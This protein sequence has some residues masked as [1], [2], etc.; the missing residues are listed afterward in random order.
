MPL[1]ILH[2]AVSAACSACMV[3]RWLRLSADD[4]RFAQFL[5]WLLAGL[6]VMVALIASGAVLGPAG[7]GAAAGRLGWGDPLWRL[8]VESSGLVLGVT[9]LYFVQRYNLL[10]LSLSYRSLR[11][12]A[13]LLA[14]VGLVLLVGSALGAGGTDELRRAVAWGLLVALLATAIYTPL[15]QAALRR[16]V[17]LRRLLG[18][19]ITAEELE[20]FT[21]TLQSFDLGEEGMRRLTAREIGQWL[22]TRARFLPEL[23][24]PP[25]LGALRRPTSPVPSTASTPRLRI[26]PACSSGPSSRPRSHCGWRASSPACWWWRSAPP[27]AATRRGTWRR[28]SS[29]CASSPPTLEVRRPGRGAASPTERR[30]AERERLS[31]LGMVAASLAH[32]LK[33]PLSAMKAL[34]QTVHEELAAAAP[35]E[36]SGAGPGD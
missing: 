5:R 17:W 2:V 13:G 8:A 31:L 15:Q 12:F 10:R 36:R 7:A 22:A 28:S 25:A 20:R 14:L 9:F 19:S 21:R 32:E 4:A 26:S 23:R 29:C 30:L 1:V 24:P 18:V 3:L 16:F 6:G 34:A 27:R 35:G 33:N 11:R